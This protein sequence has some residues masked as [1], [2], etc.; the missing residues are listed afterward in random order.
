M[1][2]LLECSPQQILSVV[3]QLLQHLVPFPSLKHYFS[4]QLFTIIIIPQFIT[5]QN[6]YLV[7]ILEIKNASIRTRYVCHNT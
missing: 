3:F 1:G 7:T 2:L 6:L 4:F 5:C